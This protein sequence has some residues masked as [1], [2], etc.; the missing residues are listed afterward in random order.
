MTEECGME[1]TE[2]ML[3]QI[4]TADPMP[5]PAASLDFHVYFLA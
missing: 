1:G 3:E 2:G 4:C 5:L